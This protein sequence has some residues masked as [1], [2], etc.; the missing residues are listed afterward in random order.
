MT[1]NTDF[2]TGRAESPAQIKVVG[3][4][5]GGQ[6][7]VNHMIAE[8]IA[9]NEASFARMMN[10]RAREIGLEKSNF[11]NSTGLPDPDQRYVGAYDHLART[12]EWTLLAG[13]EE[14]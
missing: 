1:P 12:E 14:P 9:G 4:G 5:G 10:D 3:V 7:A 2:L 13:G 11:A 6:N 8:G